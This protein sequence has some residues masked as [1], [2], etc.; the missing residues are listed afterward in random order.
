M[1]NKYLKV[2]LSMRRFRNFYVIEN[3]EDWDEN[4]N[5]EWERFDHCLICGI[6][7]D[8]IDKQ[9][10]PAI[11]VRSSYPDP[12]GC[13]DICFIPW[14]EAKPKLTAVIKEIIAR[15]EKEIQENK[16]FLKTLE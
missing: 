8:E 3:K 13:D 7:K 11:Y 12:Y 1:I 4:Y 9:S 5:K 15:K 14:E 2:V 6:S 16:E 10:F